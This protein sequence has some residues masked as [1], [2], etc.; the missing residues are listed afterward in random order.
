MRTDLVAKGAMSNLTVKEAKFAQLLMDQ[1]LM[2]VQWIEVV[3]AAQVIFNSTTAYIG[4]GVACVTL[5]GLVRI[6]LMT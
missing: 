2:C 5:V 3:G 1:A 4:M 6:A